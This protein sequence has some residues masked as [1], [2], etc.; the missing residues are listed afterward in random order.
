MDVATAF[1]TKNRHAHSIA[2]RNTLLALAAL[3]A[4]SACGDNGSEP[5]QPSGL[6]VVGA[7]TLTGTAGESL[8]SPLTVRVTDAAGAPLGGVR[9]TFSVTGGGG[10]VTPAVDSTDAS[11]QA[12]ATWT[13]GTGTGQQTA[14]AVVSGIAAPATFVAVAAAGA[15]ATITIQA[16]DSQTAQAGAA[17]AIAPAVRLVDRFG[18]P[19]PDVSVFFSVSAGGGSVTGSGATTNAQGIATVGAWRLGTALG[20][21]RLTALAVFNGVQGN[22]V[23]F[24]AT[25]QAG[26]ASR[27]VALTSTTLSQVVSTNVTPAPSVRVTDAQGNAV[28]GVLVTFTGSSGSTVAGQT[29]TTGRTASR[30]WMA[31]CLA[32]RCRATRSPSPHPA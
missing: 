23:E 15:P 11:G 22:P 4:L 9:V 16:G 31:G 19:V 20:A 30:P 28:A 18:N 3:V 17:V 25:A 27:I 32:R 13:L 6:T 7:A 10:S 2:V 21:N 26:P 24:S 5:P 8:P 12:S 1:H 29:K 14:Q